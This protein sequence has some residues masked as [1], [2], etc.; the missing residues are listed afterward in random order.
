MHRH[1]SEMVRRRLL[2]VASG[3]CLSILIVFKYGNFFQENVLYMVSSETE[4]WANIAIPLGISFFTFQS[5]SYVID[6]Y[7]R[8]TEP[9]DSIRDYLLYIFSFPQL[10]AGPIVRFGRVKSQIEARE[11]TSS[12]KLIGFYRFCIGLAKKV[13]IADILAQQVDHTFNLGVGELSTG[14]AWTGML[15]FTF[16]IYF[17]FSAYSDMAI[18]LGRMMGFRF[19]ENFNS[20]FIAKS[21]TEFW[22]RWHITLTDF[23]RD[24]VYIPLGGNRTS[25]KWKMYRNLW[26]VFILTGIWHGASWNFFIWGI[27]H[28][29]F[30]LLDKLF[31]GKVMKRIGAM[32]ILITFFIVAFG[33]VIFK[34][35]N[36]EQLLEY[37]QIMFAGGA[38]VPLR[39][40]PSFLLVLSISALLS[41]L[42]V[43]QF[44]KRLRDF[45]IR[46]NEYSIVQHAG[47]TIAS[48]IVFILSLSLVVSSDPLPF[49]YF[50]F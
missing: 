14:M 7:R 39:I 22:R 15:A 37:L 20:P 49:I 45:F 11:S 42:P 26:I 10:I 5:I 40:L 13:L 47:L 36:I 48:L 17:D 6:I 41:F 28:G 8:E 23:M 19:P 38:D 18:G 12:D 50:Q 44:G 16:Q 24:Y 33:C 29:V 31:L 27:Y 35:E 21:I 3:L 46:Q 43:V 34:L 25:T 1:Q 4:I 9:L 2:Y 32:S 30:I